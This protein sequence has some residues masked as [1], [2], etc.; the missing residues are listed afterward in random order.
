MEESIS[1][2]ATYKPEQESNDLTSLAGRWNLGLNVKRANFTR[3]I[4]GTTRTIP[5]EWKCVE[6]PKDVHF[7]V[8]SNNNT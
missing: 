2:S 1:F 5:T 4:K 7:I 8:P 6:P 3:F